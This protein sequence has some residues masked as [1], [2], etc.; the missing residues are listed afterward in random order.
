[1]T[2]HPSTSST[3]ATPTTAPPT[4]P[5][6]PSWWWWPP[7]VPVDVGLA[8]H[9]TTMRRAI[10]ASGCSCGSSVMGV[11]VSYSLIGIAKALSRLN[12]SMVGSRFSPGFSFL[13]PQSKHRLCSTQHALTSQE[14]CRG[15]M[16]TAPTTERDRHL[17][18]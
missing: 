13:I 4:S 12:A 5:P 10:V 9:Y 14:A 7:I 15:S 11:I 6:T 2:T 8:S 18:I 3:S 17:E 16:S 1:M